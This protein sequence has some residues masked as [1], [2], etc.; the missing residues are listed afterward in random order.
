MRAAKGAW[1]VV[2]LSLASCKACKNEHPY[3]PYSIDGEAP[4]SVDAQEEAAPIVE[5]GS[6]ADA[7]AVLAPPNATRWT[8]DGM[9]LLAPARTDFA[10]SGVVFV[11]GLTGDFDGDGTPDAI[12]VLKDASE[13]PHAGAWF[14][15]GGPTGVLPG[16]PVSGLELGSTKPSCSSDYGLARIGLHSVFLEA[17][18]TCAETGAASRS[19]AIVD[20][21]W[22]ATTRLKGSLE[23]PDGAPA[24]ALEAE[25]WDFDHDGQDDLL[26]RVSLEGGGPPFEPGPR[27]SAIVKWL[28]RRT[29]LSR[30]EEE[31][32][33][34]FHAIAG[35]AAARASK[36][37][38]AP[39]VPVLVHE[40]R[41]LF[42]AM[43]AEGKALRVKGLFYDRGIQC[44]TTHALEELALAETRAY[45][46]MGDPL[47][48]AGALDLEGVP[49]STK[50]VAK[51]TEARGWI[52]K[53]APP[54]Q[55]TLLRAVAAIPRSERGRSPSWG[56]LAFEPSGKLL[57]RTPA[58]V[59]RVDP[60]TGD[61]ADA[62]GMA[63]WPSEVV[64]PDG[65]HRLID[66]YDPCD[67]FALRA[68]VVA[69]GGNDAKDVLLPIEPTVGLR[70]QGARGVPVRAVP[71]AWGPLGLELV[72]GGFPVVVA[73]DL[74][75]A[76][77]LV[78]PLG[79]P[80]T[81]GAPRSPDG[82][83]LVVP[84]TEGI[85]VM[86]A[87]SRLLRAKELE[88][89][90]GELYDCAVSDDGARVACARGGRAFVGV[91]PGL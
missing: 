4:P 60:Q 50:T 8:L 78:A 57:V 47:R 12:T 62:G 84:V 77:P 55:A 82:R 72:V 33:G 18:H 86:G 1:P 27:V 14:Y 79:Q 9:T 64:S 91:W 74:G 88:G 41:A 87:R 68:T 13:P 26:L 15:R 35:V 11:V 73:A 20:L 2:L 71:I 46:T 28:D 54:A 23:D 32:E 24:L 58:G 59:A 65:T 38:E 43:C 85:L 19:F 22:A 45:V 42:V 75:N 66:S 17:R 53:I 61:E 76:A 83:T 34:S 51:V 21:Q 31:P 70:C 56:A 89:A 16:V 37:N 40:A 5:G 80:V 36:P 30:E 81:L 25:R 90:Y 6:Y 52:E 3:V 63:A 67:G 10:A 49:P 69:T 39:S 29:G 44:G 48:A 7:R